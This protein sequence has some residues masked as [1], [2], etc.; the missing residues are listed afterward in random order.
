MHYLNRKI[1][2]FYQGITIFKERLM[3]KKVTFKE[4]I[5]ERLAHDIC[6]IQNEDIKRV[7]F[8]R[9]HTI[10]VDDE[11]YLSR[12]GKKHFYVLEDGD[13][14]L[15]HEEDAAR[16]M[17][18]TINNGHFLES[19]IAMGKIN[20]LAKTDGFF[21]VDSHLLTNFNL[22]GNISAACINNMSYVKKGQVVAS[23]RII[24]LFTT[25]QHIDKIKNFNHAQA[26]FRILP[27]K[28]SN[29][30]Q[31]T[32]GSEVASAL[33]EDGFKP[34]LDD[35]LN[36]FDLTI[37]NYQ[38]VIDDKFEIT[39]K[40]TGAL[41]AGADLI[42]VTGGMSVDPDDLTPGAIK[43]SGANIITYGTPIIPGSMFLYSTHKDAVI[44][45]LPGAVIFEQT[46]AFDLLLPY[47]LT[48]T[49]IDQKDIMM[50]A[51]GGLLDG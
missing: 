10:S 17:F 7:A 22:L 32:T 28:A 15:I 9:N 49:N 4:A 8:K 41:N 20:F 13:D 26:M 23:M 35:K 48:K 6:E 18:E 36:T 19:D 1:I 2:I 47:A 27:I 45:G 38:V 24:S 51:V 46:T 43:D 50:M 29:I 30:H 37:N 21:Q 31:I 39:N 44:L 14:H 25:K 40:I 5:G 42:L 34:K 33:V 11:Q 12:L 3:M 16:I